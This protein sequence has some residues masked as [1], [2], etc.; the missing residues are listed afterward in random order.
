MYLARKQQGTYRL[1][2]FYCHRS[3]HTYE[4]LKFYEDHKIKPVGMPLYTTHL[5]QPP[6][7]CIF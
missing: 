6:N 3:H 4:F 5:L 7:V 1:L 2:L